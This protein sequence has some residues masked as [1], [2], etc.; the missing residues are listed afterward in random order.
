QAQA[1]L[2]GLTPRTAIEVAGRIRGLS[3]PRARHA[4]EQIAAELEITEWLD[5]RA[6]PEGRGL[7]GGVRRLVAFAMAAVVPTPLVV[8]DEPTNDVD[9][10]RRRRLW[11]VVR[12]L[13]DHGSGILLVTH[14]VVEA[15]RLVDELVVLDRGRVVASGSPADLRGAADDDLRLELRL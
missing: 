6:L 3:A 14:N 12:R 15:E 1:P 10:A 5:R 2:D 7:S 4:A 13:A 9:A 8:L 11:E